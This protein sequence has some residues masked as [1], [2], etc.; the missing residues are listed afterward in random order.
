MLEYL[1]LQDLVTELERV[2]TVNEVLLGQEVR[3][4]SRTSALHS[5]F[6]LLRIVDD[7]FESKRL[8]SA[9]QV[10]SNA[11]LK[12]KCDLR[13]DLAVSTKFL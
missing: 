11:L 7:L 4:C 2:H 5:R 6:A 8:V 3:T 9:H 10:Q 13:R 1:L 12:F